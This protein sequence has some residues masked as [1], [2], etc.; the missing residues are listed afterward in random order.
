MGDNG[1]VP[2]VT[3][4]GMDRSGRAILAW[5]AATTEAH[6]EP[7]DLV[8]EFV[9]F[10]KTSVEYTPEFPTLTD[11]YVRHEQ[12]YEALQVPEESEPGRALAFVLVGLAGIVALC[13]IYPFLVLWL[14]FVVSGGDALD[15]WP[16]TLGVAS[17]L[18][19]VL[20]LLA[21]RWIP[22]RVALVLIALV[23]LAVKPVASA[24]VGGAG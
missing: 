13:A 3:K 17:T 23:P 6:D 1:R 10:L 8:D 21:D 2:W 7:H 12:S 18:S 19:L 15:L 4:A 20:A 22:G 14:L 9:P 11:E 24:I 5:L 16:I